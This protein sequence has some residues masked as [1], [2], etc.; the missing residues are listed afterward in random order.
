[1]KNSALCGDH[2]SFCPQCEYSNR[3]INSFV[4][5]LETLIKGFGHIYDTDGF[6]HRFRLCWDFHQ[7]LSSSSDHQA[8]WSTT[9]PSQHKY[10]RNYP[11][12]P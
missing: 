8:Q 1:V 11:R 9:Q 12:I 5:K 10:T 2:V 6:F 4:S 7:K 3:W